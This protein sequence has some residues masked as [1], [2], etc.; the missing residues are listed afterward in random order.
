MILDYSGQEENFNLLFFISEE[1]DAN[2]G[3]APWVGYRDEDGLR[4]KILELSKDKRNFVRSPPSGVTFD[5]EYES[6][7]GAALTLLREDP[8][9]HEMR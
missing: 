5:F 7:S 9:L 8:N 6:I 1:S 4:G 3:A 2:V